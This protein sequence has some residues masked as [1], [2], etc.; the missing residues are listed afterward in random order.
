MLDLINIMIPLLQLSTAQELLKYVLD[1]D[2]VLLENSDTTTQKKSYRILSNIVSSSKGLRGGTPD[3]FN[4]VLD[5]L[6]SAGK[7]SLS[8]AKHVSIPSFGRVEPNFELSN[9][10]SGSSAVPERSDYYHAS[11]IPLPYSTCAPRSCPRH[12]GVQR[13]STKRGL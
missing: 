1:A 3:D 7:R 12:K 9:N 10:H 6:E 8:G 4:R 2:T 5:R 11:S 13:E